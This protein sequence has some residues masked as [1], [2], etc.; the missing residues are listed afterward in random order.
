MAQHLS[1]RVP[2]KD[3]GYCGLVCDKPCYNN[4][5][6]RLKNIS[7]SRDDALEEGLRGQP[8]AGHE[9]EIPC[10][11]EGGVFMSERPHTKVSI[12]PYK[13]SNPG[14]HGHFRE[15][16]LVYPPFSLPARPFAWTMLRMGRDTDDENIQRLTDLYGIDYDARREPVLP[17]QT[18]WV[19]DAVNQRAIFKTFYQNVIPHES[20]VVAYAKQVPFLDDAKRVIMGIG[21]VDSITDPPDHN[22]TEE[23][24]LRS[25]L[26]ET[27]IG[28]TIR[29]DRKNGFLLPYREMMEYAEGHPEFDIRTIAVVAEDDY[30]EEFSYATEHLSYDAVISVLLQTIKSLEI[31]KECIPGNWQDCIDWANNRLEEV[32]IDRG[33]YPGLGAMLCAA[34]FK[35]GMVMAGEIKAQ[36]AAGTDY[37]GFVEA[38]IC[39]PDRVF[40]GGVVRSIG[41]TE[42]RAFLALSG[43]RKALFWLL[44]RLSVTVQQANMVFHIENRAAAGIFCTDDGILKNPY[45]LY[46][47]TR[48]CA[49][50]YRIPVRKV[51]MAVFPPEEIQKAYPLAAPSALDSENDQRR[52]R[53][54]AVNLLEQKTDY[55][56]TVYPESSLI[57]EINELPIDPGCKVTGDICNSMK[58]FLSDELTFVECGD[59][60]TAYQLRRLTEMDDVIRKAV[61][62]RIHAKRHVVAEDWSR[63]VNDAFNQAGGGSDLSEMERKARTEKAAILKELAEARLSVL[64]GG[65]GTG[66]TTLLALLCKS[67]KIRDGG[68]LLLAPTGKARVRM[69]QAMQANQVDADAKTVA[70]FL[71]SN[72]RFD[73]N[74]MRYQLS[75]REAKDVPLTVIIDECSMLTEEMFGAL[76]QALRKAQRIILVGDP[77]QLPPIGA[78]RPFVDL[79][80]FLKKDDIPAFPCVGSCY[81][82][83]TVTRRQQHSDGEKRMDMALAEWYSSTSAELD[84]EIFVRLQA[85]QCGERVSFKTWSTPEELE[86][87]ILETVSSETG[88]KGIDDIAGFDRSLGGT[89]VGQYTYFNVG[90]AASSEKW[91][92]LAPIRN[93]PQGAVNINHIIHKKYR[94]NFIELAKRKR[95]RKIPSPLGAE[96]IVYGDKVINIRNGKR[97]AWPEDA[98]S[99][100]YVANGEIGIAAGSFGK[101]TKC[102]NVEFSS[103]PHYTYSY[104]DKEFGEEQ[105]AALELA[106]ALTVHKAQGSEFDTVILV[107]SEPCG[108]L[109]KEL[110]YTAITRQK[111]RLVI[112][113]NEKAYHLKDYASAEF[114]DCA[115]RFTCLF[116]MPTIVEHKQRCYEASLIHK[117]LRGEL[118]RSKSEVIIANML[119]E[120]GIEYEYERELSLG[121]DG[122]RIPDFTI[123]DAESGTLIYW[124]HCGM[125][126]DPLYRR[127]WEEKKAAYAKHGIIEGENLIV[128]YDN[129]DG[130]IDC[131]AIRS[132][133]EKYF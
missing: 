4:A 41:E 113:Y 122:V 51:D 83:L 103:Q 90:C 80:R 79:V 91:Q 73:H 81:G 36:M 69:R 49:E 112:L 32:W 26:W 77:N 95:Y 111:N 46:E 119:F 6:L 121:E 47:C 8:I 23:G 27:M 62:K 18:N 15:T 98:G 40:S 68:I 106:Y 86:A 10:I 33:A 74:T 126:S 85:N 50:M 120:A 57:V 48:G 24:E 58:A 55:G 2:W 70:Q 99:I 54:I 84:D 63:I 110:L 124:E 53:A 118:V 60:S 105:E 72:G 109:S 116:Q 132:M 107:I 94:E 71:I 19:Q 123:D 44:A 128:S 76:M 14:T 30:F 88:M 31:I 17:F 43:Q 89:E 64:V 133:I 100:D 35:Y 87:L 11:S 39:N 129:M 101:Q 9:N 104:K 38:A 125:M 42:R 114:S 102:L 34:G 65:A 56:H 3:N 7:D 21:F 97:K 66:K 115:R 16:E 37:E 59:G 96:G 93:M 5:C 1:I 20:L 12:H 78:G 82:E 127:R 22:H 13:E 29:E 117:T 25:I 52:V 28:H 45:L 67:P 108:L 92:I 61:H 130:G 131:V 75:D